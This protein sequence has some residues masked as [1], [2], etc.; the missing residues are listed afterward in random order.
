MGE[1][2][3]LLEGTSGEIQSV[4]SGPSL[5][6]WF[7]IL[8]TVRKCGFWNSSPRGSLIRIAN[9]SDLRFARLRSYPPRGGKAE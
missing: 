2:G 7:G 1:E 4:W 8:G 3:G 6:L 5:P 9:F